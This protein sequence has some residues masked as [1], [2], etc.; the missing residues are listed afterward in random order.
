MKTLKQICLA[1]IFMLLLPICVSAQD[2]RQRDYRTI[3]ADGLAQL[4]I[5]ETEKRNKVMAELMNTGEKGMEMM[6]GML[7]P[8]EK[9]K[10][11]IV[12]YA[13][14]GV[15]GYVTAAGNIEQRE[16]IR[17][18]LISSVDVCKDNDN[19]AFLLSQL[20]LCSTSDNIPVFVKYLGDSYLADYAIRGL[21]ATPGSETALLELME[22]KAASP[23][24]LAHAAYE[25]KLKGAEPFLLQWL[26]DADASTRKVIFKALSVCGSSASLKTLSAAAKEEG[27]GW[28]KDKEATAAYL[29]L[30]NKLIEDGEGEKAVKAG[31]KLLKNDEAYLRGAALD[32]ILSAQGVEGM[33]YVRSALGDKD[34]EVRNS[35][36]RSVSA[37]ADD[38][39]YATVAGWIS[40]LSDD[41]RID[42]INWLGSRH[43]ASQANVI[44]EAVR[45]D[46]DALAA[47]GIAAAGRI[48]GH[49]ALNELTVQLGGRHADL[50]AK[51]MLA[52]NGDIKEGIKIALGGNTG[53]QIQALRL[54]SKRKITDMSGQIFFMLQAENPDIKEAAYKA[55]PN[56]VTS[57]DADR[58]FGLLEK[59][60]S[61][62]VSDLQ[63][64][65]KN[66]ISE[67][68]PQ[69][70]CKTVE[71]YMAKSVSPALYYPILAQ[72]NTDEAVKVLNEEFT[73]KGDNAAFESLLIIN[74]PKMMDALYQIA[75]QKP[76]LK[77]QALE[78]YIPLV[79]K[80]SLQSARK[81]QL[82][83]QALDLNPSVKVQ[84]KVL[85]ALAGIRKYPS[86]M[87]VSKYLDKSETA[88]EAAAAAKTIVAK[89][90]ERLGGDSVKIILEKTREVYKTLPGA[91]SGYAVDEITNL[92]SKLLA[93]PV[94]ALSEEEKKQGFEVLFDGTSL[95]QW[96][97]NKNSYV[98]EN[99]NIYVSAGYGSGG[100]LY[101]QKEYS[102]FVLRFEFC[103]DREGVN[104]GIGIRTPM[105]V[106]AAYHG[107]EIQ[108]L[109]HDA[110][111]YKGL[112]EYQQHGSVY[113]IIPAKRVKFGPNGT[114][115]VEEIRAVGD[116]ITVTVNGEVILDGNIRTA[117][118][119][120]N[121]S[122]DGSR[123]NPHTV[124]H[125]NHP[126]LFNKKGHIGLCG[127]GAGIRFRNMRVLD[128]SK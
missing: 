69:E 17:K 31:K 57:G 101:T 28:N 102:D 94:F 128:L 24:V 59:S 95:H 5:S 7:V 29:G 58:L 107:M 74:N 108:I 83:Q 80:S 46:N 61:R 113:G 20:Q 116:H 41:A 91:D 70:Q 2:G 50:A 55:L 92:L 64:A 121:V 16:A 105:G 110:P 51:A 85:K 93:A 106:D 81:L 71:S 103:F 39:V 34:I 120:H 65:L 37:F 53:T 124:D 36:L 96:T 6:A 88:A 40:S 100:N 56:V 52:F 3:V 68:T 33:S 21:V 114:W 97:G 123:R 26:E 14:S 1:W 32:I 122:K 86:L 13:I 38:K 112:H 117:C 77:N 49:E 72:T 125:L 11:A 78:Q 45:S 4:P 89:S 10:N 119:G 12:E 79:S 99:G 87:L 19:R 60:D 126:G 67:Q 18:G 66:A 73:A 63:D 8:A 22:K 104:N 127:H 118:Q 25:S 62:Y 82:Y 115:N 76:A 54:C 23:R 30:L 42:V 75:S 84:K 98:I 109:D 44:I 48:G 43:A 27:Y 90:D 47:V 111:I 35:V 15:V 9:G